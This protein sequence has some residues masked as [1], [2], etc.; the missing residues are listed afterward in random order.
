M[1]R[2]EPI[3]Q[4]AAEWL[5]RRD[6][7]GWSAE[8][9]AALTA[10]LDESAAHEAAFW[11]LEFG[12][13]EIDRLQAFPAMHVAAEDA[14]RRAVWPRALAASIALL[15]VGIG[16]AQ[17]AEG[18]AGAWLRER[19]DSLGT[20]P[21]EYSTKG[22][23]ISS[24]ALIDGT[25]VDLNANSSI[26]VVVSGRRR[27]LWV[28]RGEV[29]FDV[30]KD[31]TRPFVIHAD[32]NVVTVLGTKFFVG[33]SGDKVTLSVVEG[34]V[35]LDRDPSF[36]AKPFVLTRG[37]VARVVGRT[38]SIEMADVDAIQDGLSWRYGMA[39]FENATLAD[40]AKQFNRYN[41][42]KIV[43]GR[44]YEAMRVGGNFRLGNIDGFLRIMKNEYG[45]DSQASEDKVIL[46]NP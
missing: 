18:G 9:E 13:G 44:D 28:D 36:K 33:K 30:A 5:M 31:R 46:G 29:F 45:I 35:R 15:A 19:W 39:H 2:A 8:D 23:Q 7:A 32:K 37:E 17:F 3:E 20:Q 14:P 24:I 26:R 34:K 12:Y 25:Q 38:A 6:E 40:V 4:A 27:E 21:V 16:T 11:R 10:W 1:S 43:V 22:G 41:E 42:R